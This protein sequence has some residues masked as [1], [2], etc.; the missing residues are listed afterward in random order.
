MDFHSV[1]ETFA[2]AWVAANTH[3]PL[4]EAAEQGLINGPNNH[5]TPGHGP[6][7]HGQPVSTVLQDVSNER[8]ESEAG[9]DSESKATDRLSPKN[10]SDVTDASKNC[11]STADSPKICTIVEVKSECKPLSNS[12]SGRQSPVD[13]ASNCSPIAELKAPY[14]TLSNPHGK[15]LPVHCIIEQIPG[16]QACGQ[17][18]ELDSYAIV[19]ND[20]LFS[21]LVRTALGKLGYSG[22][23][24]VGAKGSIQIKKWK[25]LAFD[26]ITENPEATVADILGELTTVA[27]LHIRLY[28]VPDNP[29]EWIDI[30]VRNAVLELLREMSQSK[31]AKLCPLSQPM[32]SN[33]INNRYMGKIGKEKCQ[34]FGL[35]YLTYR[36]QHPE[37]SAPEVVPND[38]PVDGRL[39]FHP[40]K[41]LPVMRDWFHSC[42]NPSR[43]ML[44]MYVDILNQGP[45]RQ[46][47]RPK[48]ALTTLKNW[49]KNEKQRE[50][51]N[52]RCDNQSPEPVKAKRKR[53]TSEIICPKEGANDNSIQNFSG[54]NS[55]D[56]MKPNNFTLINHSENESD[57]DRFNRK[58]SEMSENSS[59]VGDSCPHFPKTS[60]VEVIK[61]NSKF[62]VL[63]HAQSEND[64][65]RFVKKDIDSNESNKLN[66]NIL[67]APKIPLHEDS[68]LFHRLHTVCLDHTH[69][70]FGFS[71]PHLSVQNSSKLYCDNPPVLRTSIIDLSEN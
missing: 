18:V 29:Q 62:S 33:I 37:G 35:W 36:K 46:Q 55:Q 61:S 1:M 71:D 21:D 44:Q 42:R 32:L 11:S 64:I 58:D 22:A 9:T 38:R 14:K 69:G 57:L 6:S 65:E 23:Q 70:L 50:R 39:T 10:N 67:H 68:S 51:K 19:P 15:S 26:Q 30:T 56:N 41:E 25:S 13:T 47:E 24:I 8:R 20:T 52:Q 27:S 60:P 3:T 28:S 43:R 34:E 45:V 7:N 4:T 59:L 54:S 16:P 66:S 63:G 49:W 5:G 2:E 31:L 12:L 17:Y 48:I 40:T 53:K